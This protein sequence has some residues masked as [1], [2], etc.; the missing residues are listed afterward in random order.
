MKSIKKE[1]ITQSY[2]SD[3]QY[4]GCVDLTA[5]IKDPVSIPDTVKSNLKRFQTQSD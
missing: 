1:V 4:Q 2:I 3:Y 5:I